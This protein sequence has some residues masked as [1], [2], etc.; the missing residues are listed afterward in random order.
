MLGKA[1]TGCRGLVNYLVLGKLGKEDPDRVLWSDVRNLAVSDPVM[2]PRIMR[3]TANQST[4]AEEPVY[5]LIIS[6]HRDED[7]SEEVMRHVADT[8]L[9][10]L[11]LGEH[12]ALMV[13]HGDTE[14][15]NLHIVVNRIHPEKLTA[16]DRWKDWPKIEKSLGRQAKELG[17]RYV[18][19]RHNE[20]EQFR[21]TP[22]RV[23]SKE[24]RM[25]ERLGT[26]DQ[27]RPRW[28]KEQ[29]AEKRDRLAETI[30]KSGS[31]TELTR[32]LANDGITLERKGQ[33]IV[34]GDASGTMKLSDLKKDIRLKPLEARF[35][36]S[37]TDYELARDQEPALEPAMTQED[38]DGAETQTNA[39]PQQKLQPETPAIEIPPL[40]L[41]EPVHDPITDEIPAVAFTRKPKVGGEET[42][43]A[44]QSSASPQARKIKLPPVAG[45]SENTE[46]AQQGISPKVVDRTTPAHEPEQRR[47]YVPK[48]QPQAEPYVPRM[49]PDEFAARW[50]AKVRKLE[51]L[52][53]AKKRQADVELKKKMDEAVRQRERETRLP[54]PAKARQTTLLTPPAPERR[55][56]PGKKTRAPGPNDAAQAFEAKR[57]ADEEADLAYRLYGMGAVSQKQLARS[58]RQKAE[59]G[60]KADKHRAP[61]KVL[62]REL[63]QA[64]TLD[65]HKPSEKTKKEKTPDRR[66]PRKMT[67]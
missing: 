46:S 63:R 32:A 35:G 64:L 25:A 59:A 39:S 14:H 22:K 24:H 17:L 3:A 38:D 58:M 61:G 41:E 16:W 26:V 40:L 57:K 21:D 66:K 20:P 33:G 34:L 56:V 53:T 4:R 13:A 10:D 49:N 7:P 2:A 51:E 60:A 8:T 42:T 15:K 18:P 55:P 29:I 12:Q 50:Q 43:G 30:E 37:W 44:S 6:W 19:G 28:T 5:H 54:A 65:T 23:R 47:P 11:E 31:W 62:E 48:R 27:L 45:A 36:Q 9:E 67:R 1:A 52:E